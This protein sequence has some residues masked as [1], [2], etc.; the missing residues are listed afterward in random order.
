MYE[1]KVRRKRSG[2]GHRAAKLPVLLAVLVVIG[3]LGGLGLRAR[4]FLPG[5]S[6]LGG[7][8]SAIPA[9]EL[10]R[11][12]TELA[13]EE[14]RAAELLEHMDRY[15][16]ELL[17]LVLRNPETL[18]FV[19]GWPEDHDRTPAETV[20]EVAEGEIPLL[21]QWDPRWG[22]TDYG[23]G[24]MALN[25]CGPTA[26]AMVVCGLTGRTDV[27][28]HVVGDM[29]E[30]HW[31]YVNGEGSKWKLM[32]KGGEEYG[33]TAE[34]LPLDRGRMVR[35]LEE[36]RPIICSMGPGDFTTSGHFIVLTGVEDGLFRVN[37]PNRRSNSEKL[38]D[39]D[40]LS[41]Q[42]RNLWAYAP[43]A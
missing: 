2:R 32:S 33:L 24:P 14:P 3:I 28:P 43:A 18:E 23:D 25:G 41:G 1:G 10:A 16:E 13:S 20:G 5:A 27:T 39:Y 26:L 37:D 30:R 7:T 17:E 40:T 31:W 38:W 11:Q 9:D 12:L 15:P 34:E 22:Y 6:G 35:A 21:M 19:L 42:I 4:G 8:S 36:G 29:A